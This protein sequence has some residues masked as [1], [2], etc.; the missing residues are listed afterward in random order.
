M[1]DVQ[2][3]R[4]L[5]SN[6]DQP[7]TEISIYDSRGQLSLTKEERIIVKSDVSSTK[8]IIEE[9]AEKFNTDKANV[10]HNNLDARNEESGTAHIFVILPEERSRDT[11]ILLIQCHNFD[12]RSMD[13][14]YFCLRVDQK[15]RISDFKTTIKNELRW[16]SLELFVKDYHMGDDTVLR[17]FDLH[18]FDLVMASKSISRMVTFLYTPTEDIQTH[19]RMC[20]STSDSVKIVKNK[21]VCRF[22]QLESTANK[23]DDSL[24]ITCGS[25]LLKDHQCFGLTNKYHRENMYQIHFAPRDAIV[26]ILNFQ[27]GKERYRNFGKATILVSPNCSSS[28]L[29]HEAAK[30][31]HVDPKAVKIDTENNDNK[32]RIEESS[33]VSMTNGLSNRCALYAGIKKKKTLFVKHPVTKTTEKIANLYALEPVSTLRK[34]IA[35]KYGINELQIVIKHKGIT[36]KDENLLYEYPIKNNVVLDLHI[37]ERRM[38]IIANVR[39]KR[40]KLSLIID[41]YEKTTIGDILTYC[42]IQLK[43]RSNY[44]RC[45]YVGQCI[46]TNTTVKAAGLTIGSELIILHFEEE[47]QLQGKL[48][49]FFLA[50]TDGR[51]IIRYG[52]MAGGLLLRGEVHLYINLL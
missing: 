6:S 41:D 27:T 25:D 33:D 35:Q 45:L 2:L 30:H 16:K 5:R 26:C 49:R 20:I 37:Y 47:E 3:R 50:D 34:L 11:L 42:A 19:F 23:G 52:S 4:A 32:Q 36:L 13:D 8:D 39:F 40:T 28:D 9:V 15:Q 21:L 17:D 48:Q 44:S 10:V 29:R 1:Y 31:M 24:H 12:Q 46:A 38:H 14:A 18:D 22:D 7:C 43:Y 51:V